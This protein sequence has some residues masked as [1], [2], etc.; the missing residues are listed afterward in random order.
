[1]RRTMTPGPRP[2][3]PPER[4]PGC[5]HAFVFR[6]LGGVALRACESCGMTHLLWQFDNGEMALVLVP[7]AGEL[8]WARVVRERATEDSDEDSD[9]VD[10]TLADVVESLLDLP[11]GE[12]E[13]PVPPKR[14]QR[15]RAAQPVPDVQEPEQPLREATEAG[16]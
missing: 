7:E 2:F 14:R 3:G 10:D 9:D 5:Q 16:Q 13:R 12:D 15:R 8:G 4:T 1:M 11:P 6:E